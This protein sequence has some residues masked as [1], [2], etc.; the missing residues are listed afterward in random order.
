M[1]QRARKLTIAAV[2]VALFVGFIFLTKWTGDDPHSISAM[3]DGQRA[4]I[5]R[6][7][8]VVGSEYVP[9]ETVI[10]VASGHK[11]PQTDPNGN[12]I[13][14]FSGGAEAD[15]LTGILRNLADSVPDTWAGDAHKAAEGLERA[16]DGNLTEKQIDGYI[17]SY[18]SL[19]RR[20][21]KDCKDI[22]G[23]QVDFGSG[24]GGRDGP[25][26]GG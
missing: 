2:A 24:R 13:T 5:A 19:Q 14:S 9:Y 1:E 8:V 12:A 22:K 16:F 7:C 18:R 23:A 25:F 3:D 6:F 4:D 10:R 15:F 21:A 11:A 20:A 17:A 26:D